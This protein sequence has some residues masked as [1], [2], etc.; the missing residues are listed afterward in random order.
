[1]KTNLILGLS[2]GRDVAP[3]LIE[4]SKKMEYRGYD[5]VGA[6]VMDETD[7]AVKK[8]MGLKKLFTNYGYHLSTDLVS[9]KLGMERD[10]DLYNKKMET[11]TTTTRNSD[12]KSDAKREQELY[13]IKSKIFENN[14]QREDV[15][16]ILE[17]KN[18]EHLRYLEIYFEYS[19]S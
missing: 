15:K 6:A 10:D 16:Q 12:K 7:I 17:E 9:E 5:S 8:G 18:E 1:M 19:C 13:E 4:S 2:G 14:E 11:K 3:T